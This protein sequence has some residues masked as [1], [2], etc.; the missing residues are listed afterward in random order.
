MFLIFAGAAMI[1]SLVVLRASFSRR[2]R[3][4]AALVVVSLIAVAAAAVSIASD[5]RTLRMARAARPSALSIHIVRQGD[6]WQLD[7]ARGNVA[8]TT[9][10]ELHVPA[11]TAVALSWSGAP[12]PTVDGGFCLPRGDES[13]CTL[14]AGD[15]T[16]ARFFRLWPPMR[17]RL[18]IVV[19]PP[20]QF[21]AWLR[22]ESAPARSPSEAALF[23][24]AGC[25]YCHAVRGVADSP[26]KVAPDLTHFAARRTIDATALPNERGFLSGWIVHSAALEHGSLMPQNRL[27][28]RVLH[29]LV[30]YLESLR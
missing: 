17:T 15:A 19:D 24:S 28:P 7:Y 14:V 16:E 21:E 8:F 18:P 3:G 29:R 4:V 11:G 23:E 30:D 13:R 27:D 2:R 9:A 20:A 22:N 5:L 26:W 10:N 1:W 12:A 25:A 6:W